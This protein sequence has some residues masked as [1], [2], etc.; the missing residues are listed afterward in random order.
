MSA[1]TGSGKTK[2]FFFV[3]VEGEFGP[4]LISIRRNEQNRDD[5]GDDEQRHTLDSEK[6]SETDQKVVVVHVRMI[7]SED[8]RGDEQD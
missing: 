7:G 8:N 5:T 2:C 6:A 1:L 3:F 4:V